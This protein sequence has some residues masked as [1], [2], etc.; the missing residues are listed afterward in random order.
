LLQSFKLSAV[1][2]VGLEGLIGNIILL[3][4]WPCIQYLG[5]EDVTSNMDRLV[6][7]KSDELLLIYGAY[8]FT[9]SIS[10]YFSVALVAASGALT[11][12]YGGHCGRLSYGHLPY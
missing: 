10:N 2:V 4:A 7:A 3:L 6:F 8:L 9:V 11:K 12:E 1:A 5:Y